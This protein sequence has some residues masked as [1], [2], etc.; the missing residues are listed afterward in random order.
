MIILRSLVTDLGVPTTAQIPGSNG[1]AVSFA[2]VE[3]S[4]RL[5]HEDLE[6]LGSR[7]LVAPGRTAADPFNDINH[8]TAVLG[9]VS[10]G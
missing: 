4:W 8:G 7:V 1:S 5:D 6:I 3:Y 10:G 9:A 2:D